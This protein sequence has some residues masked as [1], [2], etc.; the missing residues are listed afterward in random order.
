[1][2]SDQNG[3]HNKYGTR[4]GTCHVTGNS[5]FYIN[6]FVVAVKNLFTW[7]YTYIYDIFKLIN[8]VINIYIDNNN[9]N[10]TTH[11]IINN[12]YFILSELE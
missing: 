12:I 10:Q 7:N 1:M 5:G 11:L 6:L 9:I 4:D 8:K 2:F 3:R